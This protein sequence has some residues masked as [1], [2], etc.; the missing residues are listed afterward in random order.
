MTQARCNAGFSFWFQAP[1]KKTSFFTKRS[2]SL[3][4]SGDDDELVCP[5]G[6]EISGVDLR[7]S[8]LPVFCG[9][10]SVLHLGPEGFGESRM[11]QL[12]SACSLR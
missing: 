1:K 7:V 3:A 5:L 2:R 4:G 10:A 12:V 9:D 11:R 8:D 6:D